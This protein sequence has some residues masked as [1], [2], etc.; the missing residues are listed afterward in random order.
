M[1]ARRRARGAEVTSTAMDWLACAGGIVLAVGGEILRRRRARTQ[2]QTPPASP[3]PELPVDAGPFRTPAP[4]PPPLGQATMFA[5]H[6]LLGLPRTCPACGASAARIW[7]ASLD[8]RHGGLNASTGYA[9]DASGS[10]SVEGGPVVHDCP[11]QLPKCKE[12]SG[13]IRY[14]NLAPFC[15]AECAAKWAVVRARK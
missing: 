4:A 6:D 15:Q 7:M 2:V 12:C 14:K 10:V 8:H 13:P 5:L 3:E 1:E 9:C 11:T